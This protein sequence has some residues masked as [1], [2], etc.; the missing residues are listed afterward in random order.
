[1]MTTGDVADHTLDEFEMFEKK[2][3]VIHRNVEVRVSGL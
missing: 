2:F 1:M 3:L